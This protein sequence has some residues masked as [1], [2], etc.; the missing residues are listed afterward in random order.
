MLG[1]TG[2]RNPLFLDP[3]EAE[4]HVDVIADGLQHL[5]HTEVGT[6]DREFSNK[7]RTLGAPWKLGGS[8]S[9]ENH[10]ERFRDAVKRKLTG[11][12]ITPFDRPVPVLRKVIIGNCLA[13]KKSGL[14]RC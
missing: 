10:G 9:P 4:R 14:L 2:R 3:F 11:Q 5:V 6:L 7:S 8:A 13:L 12:L 1:A